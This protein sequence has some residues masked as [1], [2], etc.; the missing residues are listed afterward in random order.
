MAISTVPQPTGSGAQAPTVQPQQP[1]GLTVRERFDALTARQQDEILDKHRHWNVEHI[2]WWDGV[3]DCFKADM[4]AI[5]ID[6]DKM[7]FS[8]FWSQGDGACFE[9]RVNDWSKFLASL[10]Y[11]CPALIALAEQAWSFS[12]KHS[13]H[14][15]HEN[16]TSFT[17]DMV[18]PDDY[19]EDVLGDFIDENS[20]YSTDI[21]N[22]AFVAILQGYDYGN[23]RDEFEEAFKD[24]MRTLYNQLEAE[25][26]H[27]TSDEAILD[28]L[29]AN[30][31]LED[32]INSITEEE[33]YA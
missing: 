1:R 7:Y 19:T 18:S 4:D 12:V 11:T 22:A 21:Q 33:Q 3:Y 10:G 23:L 30:D 8:G 2:D 6:V 24:H 32:A 15:F 14:Y 13:G 17:H 16:C 20:P 5:G 31:Q 26:D 25:H 28:S 29:E 9:G 27:L